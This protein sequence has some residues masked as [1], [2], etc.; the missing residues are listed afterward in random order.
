MPSVGIITAVDVGAAGDTSSGGEDVDVGCEEV[1]VES[2][3]DVDVG[4]VGEDV[5][6]GGEDVDVESDEDVDVESE[7]A[8]GET[9]ESSPV[10]DEQADI[11]RQPLATGLDTAKPSIVH[12]P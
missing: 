10:F 6:V 5:D 12:G 1:D 4:D 9:F 7:G 8:P 3:E 11:H 2:D